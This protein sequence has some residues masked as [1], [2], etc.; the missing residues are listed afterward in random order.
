MPWPEECMSG[1]NCSVL[2]VRFSSCLML[3]VSVVDVD[4]YE[5]PAGNQLKEGSRKM[6][7]REMYTPRRQQRQDA[8]Q[9]PAPVPV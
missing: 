8:T 5:V 2:V 1:T 3:Q 4:A 7:H 9:V 6:R